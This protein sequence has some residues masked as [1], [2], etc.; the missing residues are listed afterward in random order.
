M[1]SSGQAEIDDTG[2]SGA[3]AN[4]CCRRRVV[5]HVR[6]ARYR[7]GILDIEK[8]GIGVGI[9]IQAVRRSLSLPI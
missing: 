4:A 8:A 3:P 1:G 9:D 6:A 5:V 7:R 2:Q